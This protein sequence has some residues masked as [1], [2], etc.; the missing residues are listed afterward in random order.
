MANGILREMKVVT[1]GWVSGEEDDF[2][3][4]CWVVFF[5]FCADQ[6]G[7]IQIAY[8]YIKMFNFMPISP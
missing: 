1:G 5:R 3:F 8:F 2:T 6:S 7:I 4:V